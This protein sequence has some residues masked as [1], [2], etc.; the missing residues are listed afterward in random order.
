MKTKPK[1]P[2]PPEHLSPEAKKLW[3]SSFEN[4]LLDDQAAMVLQAGLEA[5]DRREQARAAIFTDGAVVMDRWGVPKVSPWVAIE[6][7]SAQTLYKAFRL[8][9]M[10]LAANGEGRR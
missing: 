1:S 8:L 3:Q 6:R 7:D 4:Y 2:K 9:G 10:D 5:L